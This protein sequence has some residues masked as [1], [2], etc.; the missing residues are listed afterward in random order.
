MHRQ[1]DRCVGI[2]VR[3]SSSEMS[4]DRQRYL[5]NENTDRRLDIQVNIATKNGLDKTKREKVN[6]IPLNVTRCS[7]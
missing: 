2:I 6:A 3:N 4:G 7:F 5:V 1:I